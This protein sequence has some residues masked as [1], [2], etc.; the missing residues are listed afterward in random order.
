[1]LSTAVH[2]PRLGEGARCHRDPKFNPN[3]KIEIW[4]TNEISEVGGPLKD[5]CLYITVILGPFESKVFTHYNWCGGPFWKQSSLV[6]HYSRVVT[7]CTWSWGPLWRQ[8]TEL[9][10][11]SGNIIWADN[12]LFT[13]HEEYLRAKY[14][15][16]TLKR[17]ARGKCLSRLP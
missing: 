10:C 2:T 12:K 14:L 16:G 9:W 13:K 6:I 1:M 8:I 3:P 7:H 5:K 11:G 15:A 17:G 4:S